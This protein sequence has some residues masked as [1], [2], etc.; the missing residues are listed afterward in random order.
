L[1]H[2]RQPDRRQLAVRPCDASAAG[3][4]LRAPEA[5]LSD[6]IIFSIAVLA[7]LLTPGPTNALLASSGALH[8][9]WR[10]ARLL[11]AELSGYSLG[12]VVAHTVV[13]PLADAVEGVRTVLG[14]IVGAYLC[15]VAVKVWR[16][17][18]AR[19]RAISWLDVFATTLLNPKVLI[20]SLF[21]FPWQT[22]AI[23]KYFALFWA[24]LVPVG[25]SW[26][27]A[28]ALGSR[29]FAKDSAVVPKSAAVALALL[30]AA[31]IGLAFRGA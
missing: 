31:V 21:V 17:G 1:R 8:G 30:G 13:A 2:Q 9:L 14:C 22:P 11:T 29:F 26:I 19:S 23:L 10:S 28:G 4:K 25:F 6:P 27:A 20:F 7:I 15:W 16:S 18:V 5:D 24:V 12:I 3:W